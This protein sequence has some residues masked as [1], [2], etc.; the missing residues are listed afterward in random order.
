MTDYMAVVSNSF[1]GPAGVSLE[2]RSRAPIESD[3]VRIAVKAAGVNAADLMSVSGT[4][5]DTPPPPFVPGFEAAGEIIE[6]GNAV[7]DLRPGDRV[8]SAADHR[9]FAEELVVD[10]RLCVSVP[11]VVAFSTAAAGP[12]AF[13]TAFVGLVHRARLE[14]GEWLLIMGGA[15]NIGGGALQIGQILG[16]RVIAPGGGDAACAKLRDLGADHV[17]DYHDQDVAGRVAEITGGHGADVI[18]DAVTGKAFPSTFSALAKMGRHIIA[19][20]AGGMPADAPVVPLLTRTSALVGVDWQHFV[21]E[22]PDTA[23]AALSA[24]AGWWAR[25]WITPSD[26]ETRP[27]AEAR[28]L[29]EEMATGSAKGKVVLTCGEDDS[30]G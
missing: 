8:L 4:H 13:G 29:L 28:A 5:Q 23:F 21:R 16:A 2:T 26:P 30:G 17:I 7:H 1:D 20:A 19:G 14:P 6:V 25:G 27:L 18:F 22:D 24:I 10:R 12:V 3:W 11:D 9:A 15:G